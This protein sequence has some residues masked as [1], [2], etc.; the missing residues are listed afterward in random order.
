MSDAEKIAKAYAD[1][2]NAAT[3][4]GILAKA[5]LIAVKALDWYSENAGAFL[6]S[7]LRDEGEH[8]REALAKIRGKA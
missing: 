3:T 7:G 5:L 8:A 2:S 6:E 1:S 4:A